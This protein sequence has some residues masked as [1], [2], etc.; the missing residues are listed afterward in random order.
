MARRLL[1]IRHAK[2]EQYGET[3][4]AR[5]LSGRG[6]RDARAAGRWLSAAG[7]APDQVF[8]SDATRAQQ[9]WEAIASGLDAKP[10]VTTDARIYDNTV[11]ALLTVAASAP[12]DASTVALVG[13]NPS[14]HA[15]ALM[16]D[17]GNGDGPT[18]ARLGASYPTMGVAVFEIV[19]EWDELASGCGRLVAFETPRA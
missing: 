18:R 3:D 6:R 14:M 7:F 19:V 13:H 5:E 10:N 15:T 8:V 2:A 9:T 11:P 4:A 16:L 12:V 17:D 1:L